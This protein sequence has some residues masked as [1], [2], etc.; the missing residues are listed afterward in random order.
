[1]ICRQTRR[2]AIIGVDDTTA[3]ACMGVLG[4]NG[5]SVPQRAGIAG[6]NDSPDARL[7]ECTSF[8][9]STTHI[10]QRMVETCVTPSGSGRIFPSRES[11]Y[12]VVRK[13]M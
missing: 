10:A 7:T 4:K 13:T 12:L 11:G 3:I 6:F 1:M 9:V 5:V 2:C 8:H